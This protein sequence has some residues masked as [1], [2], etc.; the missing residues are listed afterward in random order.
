MEQAI[1]AVTIFLS[2]NHYLHR[3]ANTEAKLGSIKHSDGLFLWLMC[4]RYKGQEW[5]QWEGGHL[6]EVE[7]TA[8]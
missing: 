4:E 5:Q 8:G 2:L 1:L 3:K 6:S 7:E